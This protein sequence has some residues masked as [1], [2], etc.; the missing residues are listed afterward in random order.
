MPDYGD[1]AIYVWSIT[2]IGV[3]LPALMLGLSFLR[4]HLTKARPRPDEARRRLRG[5]RPISSSFSSFSFSSWTGAALLP[6][7]HSR[8]R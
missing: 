7:P 3:V 2:L 6:L 8:Q 4:A 1:D 5:G